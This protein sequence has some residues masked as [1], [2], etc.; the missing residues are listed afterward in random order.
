MECWSE[1]IMA[2]MFE[3]HP[4]TFAVVGQALRLPAN[5]VNSFICHPACPPKRS[6]ARERSE[7]ELTG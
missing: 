4:D 5:N 6:G 7:A 2:I 3:A 1:G